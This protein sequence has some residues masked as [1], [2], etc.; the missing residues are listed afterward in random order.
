MTHL[1][2]SGIFLIGGALALGVIVGTII[3]R[4]VDIKRGL[5]AR[6][7]QQFEE[8][9]IICGLLVVLLIGG[10]IILRGPLGG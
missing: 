8:R 6:N 3:K 7:R 5:G 2:I 9:I 1:I 10:G 4:A